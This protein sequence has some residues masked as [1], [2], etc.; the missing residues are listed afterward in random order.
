MQVKVYKDDKRVFVGDLVEF[1]LEEISYE[2]KV[3]CYT[4]MIP[5]YYEFIG[6]LEDFKERVDMCMEELSYD[7]EQDIEKFGEVYCL[8]YT[9][10]QMSN[11][12]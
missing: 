7:L 6:S 4:E 10:K 2:D 9:I 5:S 8:G 3:E 11:S 12:I 1:L